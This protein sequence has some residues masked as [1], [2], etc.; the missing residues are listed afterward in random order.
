M[1]RVMGW[2]LAVLVVLGV[3]AA[4]AA[5][6]K[7][8]R[9]GLIPADDATEMLRNYEPVKQYLAKTLGLPVEL[10]VTMDYNGAIEAMRAKHIE[11]AWF[12]PFSYVL[13]AEVAGAEA[14]V[15]GVR[16]DTGTSTYKTV[17]VTH[18]DS[19]IKSIKELTGR[20]LA[21]VDPASTSGYLIPMSILKREGYTPEKDFKTTVYA[22]THNAVQLA[23]KNRKVDVGADS[24]TSFARMVKAGE[25]DPKVN[26][27]IHESAPIPGSPLVIRGDLDA[28][29]K[30][31]VQ[32]A[33]LDMDE[34]TIF[35][36]RGWGDIARYQPVT[37]KDYDVI[38]DVAK[39]L[40]LNL[41]KSK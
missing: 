38:R 32:K 29:F 27:V 30:K 2:A 22:G 18:K 6:P 12:G 23:V 21:F 7:S 15:N 41:K 1:G 20:S 37:D 39:V 28:A 33:L 25:I 24:D 3:G 35:Q 31:R 13:A 19:G 26:V 9:V 16:R 36:V 5:D 10:K 14:I 4:D 8:L 40:N 34:Q 17:F 11:M